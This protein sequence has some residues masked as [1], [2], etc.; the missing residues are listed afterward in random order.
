MF[1]EDTKVLIV[2]DMMTMR[3]IVQ[4]TLANLGFKNFIVAK[5]GSE[6]WNL[7]QQESDVGLV[8]SDWN[9]PIMTGMEF[10]KNVRGS[11]SYQS[12]PFILLTAEAEVGQVQE[13]ITVGVDSYVVKPFT[14]VTLKKSLEQTYSKYQKRS[15]A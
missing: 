10:L 12:L 5:D 2:D 15:A 11:D 1:S 6:A 14:V 7:L 9:M 3:K 13:A 4:K 8:V